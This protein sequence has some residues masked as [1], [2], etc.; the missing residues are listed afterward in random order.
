[1]GVRGSQDRRNG[2][3]LDYS[4]GWGVTAMADSPK[5]AGVMSDGG[6]GAAG[7]SLHGRVLDELLHRT[8]RTKR[9]A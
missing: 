1:M 6:D 4:K 2:E 9:E 8:K 5:R 3:H 7:E